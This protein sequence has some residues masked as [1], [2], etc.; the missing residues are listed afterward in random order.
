MAKRFTDTDKWKREWFT[1]LDLKAK[2]VWIY[3]LDQCDH[4][5]VWFVNFKLMSSQVGFKVT[6]EVFESWFGTKI[7]K[8]DSDKYFLPSFVR[9]QYP[10]GLN[11]NNHAHAGILEF[12][13]HIGMK[14]VFLRSSRGPSEDL[15]GGLQDKDKVKDKVQEKD[16]VKEKEK[17]KEYSAEFEAVWQKYPRHVDKADAYKAFLK[18]VDQAKE[19]D[20]LDRAISNYIAD[21][22]KNKTDPKFIKHLAT[23]LNEGRWRDWIDPKNGKSTLQVSRTV[24]PSV[25]ELELPNHNESERSFSKDQIIQ[26]KR[27]AGL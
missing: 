19:L 22:I 24:Y 12:L 17:K 15:H 21:L 4:R 16:K 1:E 11:P 13:E 8:V 5:G 7:K 3:I 9:F 2:M 10:K 18:N 25:H 27:S 23:F 26:M 14:D 20:I 6:K